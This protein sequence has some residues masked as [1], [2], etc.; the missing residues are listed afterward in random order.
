MYNNQWNI[1]EPDG[2]IFAEAFSER[3]AKEIF[4]AVNCMRGRLSATEEKNETSKD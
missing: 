4:N 1:Y 2:R 3:A